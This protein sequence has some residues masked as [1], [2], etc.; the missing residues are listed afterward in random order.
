MDSSSVA[1]YLKKKL[2]GHITQNHF[3]L[4]VVAVGIVVTEISPARIDGQTYRY[5]YIYFGSCSS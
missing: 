5:T 2:S 1:S 3:L 4:S